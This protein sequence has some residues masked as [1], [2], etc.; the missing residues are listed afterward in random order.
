MSKR[1]NGLSR[2]LSRAQIREDA[3]Q[4]QLAAR[5]RESEA[6]R[7]AHVEREARL[8]AAHDRAPE[9]TN[10]TAFQRSRV[11]LAAGAQAVDDA[12]AAA[13]DAM[14]QV[15]VAQQQL[16][17]VARERKTLERLDDRDRALLAVLASKAA[18]RSLDDL[19]N[20]RRTTP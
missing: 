19:A 18:Q 7:A 9:P 14:E 15:R 5:V 13:Q 6:Q 4:R 17:D 8:R 3:A 1:R 12:A 20:R 2:M 10:A 11:V 16:L